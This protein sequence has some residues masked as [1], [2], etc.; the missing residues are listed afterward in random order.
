MT[1]KGKIMWILLAHREVLIV[2]YLK[3]VSFAMGP[4]LVTPREFLMTSLHRTNITI[5]M[6]SH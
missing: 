5:E 3:P 2:S 1:K 6:S 4:E